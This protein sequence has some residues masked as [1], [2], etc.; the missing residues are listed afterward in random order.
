VA[1]PVVK[2]MPQS[3]DV[4]PEQRL[5]VAQPYPRI[6]DAVIADVAAGHG[7]AGCVV[8]EEVAVTTLDFEVIDSFGGTCAAQHD[9]HI[10]A[11][12]NKLSRDM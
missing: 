12:G 3:F 10:R 11:R 8:I 1:A 5:R 4:R 9:S 2:N 7:G 6:H